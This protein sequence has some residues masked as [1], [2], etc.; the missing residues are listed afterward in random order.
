MEEL[1]AV[2][3]KLHKLS[4]QLHRANFTIASKAFV[5]KDSKVRLIVFGYP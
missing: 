5:D 3:V 1:A 4:Q 2:E